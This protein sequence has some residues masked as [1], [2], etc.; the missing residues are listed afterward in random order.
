M[1]A[2]PGTCDDLSTSERRR[3]RRLALAGPVR[4]LSVAIAATNR[5]SSERC[6]MSLLLTQDPSD[7]E[8]ERSGVIRRELIQF[9][10]SRNQTSHALPQLAAQG[11]VMVSQQRSLHRQVRATTRLGVSY[12]SQPRIKPRLRARAWAVQLWAPVRNR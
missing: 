5:T 8:L 11:V 6:G 10:Q 1:E 4:T 7:S 2:L 12:F 9:F 3:P